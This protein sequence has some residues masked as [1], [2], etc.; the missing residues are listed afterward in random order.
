MNKTFLC[1]EVVNSK[2]QLQ[3]K[4]FRTFLLKVNDSYSFEV[5]EC[6]PYYLYPSA[7]NYKK[8]LCLNMLI[9]CIAYLNCI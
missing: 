1:F 3:H 9:N 4:E 7:M 8:E 6:F 2:A 5:S